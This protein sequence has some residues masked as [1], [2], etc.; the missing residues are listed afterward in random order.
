[1]IPLLYR[2]F[3]RRGER[4]GSPEPELTKKANM[5]SSLPLLLVAHHPALELPPPAYLSTPGLAARQSTGKGSR[6]A[7]GRRARGPAGCKS[8]RRRRRRGARRSRHHGP[9]CLS[10]RSPKESSLGGCCWLAG[11]LSLSVPGR[12]PPPDVKFACSGRAV[13]C[14]LGLLPARGGFASRKPLPG[15]PLCCEGAVVGL[16]PP[17]GKGPSR[18]WKKDGVRRRAEGA[19]ASR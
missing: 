6:L 14:L 9:C 17:S 11:A 12:S 18:P 5:P 19:G 8:S 10:A 7:A 15:L 1:M 2:G 13:G 3:S 4:G 16:L